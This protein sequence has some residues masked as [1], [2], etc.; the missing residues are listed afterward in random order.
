MRAR[1]GSR[2][3]IRLARLGNCRSPSRLRKVVCRPG[4]KANLKT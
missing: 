2:W 1:Q 3:R 4:V